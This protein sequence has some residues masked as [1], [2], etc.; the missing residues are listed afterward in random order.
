MAAGAVD[1]DDTPGACGKCRTCRRIES[2]NHPDVIHIQPV[3]SLIRIAQIRDLCDT[4]AMRPYE[5]ARRVVV[6]SDA[7]CLNPEASN[8][9]LKVL[10]EPP[11]HTILILTTDQASDL[12]P[13]IVSRCHRIRF[14][15][16]SRQWI[17]SVLVE[18]HAL[19]PFEAGIIAAMANGSLSDAVEM[20]RTAWFARRNWLIG[21]LDT[22]AGRPVH[23]LLAF[24]EVLAADKETLL[25]ALDVMLSWLRD[26]AIYP[27]RSQNV[28]HGDLADR[29]DESAGACPVEVLMENI[30]TIQRAQKN[31]SLN[32]NIRLTAE[33]LVLRLAQ[34]GNA[35]SEGGRSAVMG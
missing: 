4:L 2:G 12:L 9:L 5:A 27:H 20:S 6:I 1:D 31:I 17:E 30:N 35:A 3:G 13:T 18:T 24:A 23:H 21:E 33:T 14:K 19:D 16:I 11:D 8:A 26:L 7:Q 25:Q 34:A 15:P 22:L 32:A 28:I 29:I 10:E